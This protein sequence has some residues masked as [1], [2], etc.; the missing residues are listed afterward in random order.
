MLTTEFWSGT[1]VP[2]EG[3]IVRSARRFPSGFEPPCPCCGMGFR[4]ALYLVFHPAEPGKEGEVCEKCAEK[5]R[6]DMFPLPDVEETWVSVDLLALEETSLP[7]TVSEVLEED[8]SEEDEFTVRDR[9]GLKSKVALPLIPSKDVPV[10]RSP[11]E[12]EEEDFQALEGKNWRVSSK[13]NLFSHQRDFHIV[14]FPDKV[15]GF[16]VMIDGQVGK[17]RYPSAVRASGCALAAVREL[18]CRG[19]LAKKLREAPG[20]SSVSVQ[21]E[22]ALR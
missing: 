19:V 7:G 21:R 10:G 1:D 16:K 22:M 3:W 11:M 12:F 15:T 2:Q 17:L 6:D 9:Q 13:G 14:I 5:I 18:L 20:G 8:A 4:D